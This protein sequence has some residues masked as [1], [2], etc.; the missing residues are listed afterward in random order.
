MRYSRSV[1]GAHGVVGGSAAVGVQAGD[2]AQG[3][4]ASAHHQDCV[5]EDVG[6]VEFVEGLVVGVAVNRAR[7]G[8]SSM[9]PLGSTAQTW[10]SSPRIPGA[11]AEI[12]D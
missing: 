2:P 1:R 4:L 9:P 11:K 5:F 8:A 10:N 3:G 6:E 7:P 12:R